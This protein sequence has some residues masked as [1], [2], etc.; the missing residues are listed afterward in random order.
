MFAAQKGR[1]RRRRSRRLMIPVAALAAGAGVASVLLMSPAHA[2][3]TTPQPPV[4]RAAAHASEPTQAE[5]RAHVAGAIKAADAPSRSAL[6]AG[7]KGTPHTVDPKII[8]GSTTAISTAPWMAQLWYYDDRGT[9]TETDDTGFF[10][11]GTV[12]S[13]TKILTAAH[14]VKGYDWSTD[15]HGTV[16]TGTDQLPTDD[17]DGTLNMHGGT[18]YGVYRQ[19]NHPSYNSVAV[20]NDVAVLTLNVPTTAKPLPVTSATDTASYTGGTTATVYGWGRTTS[21]TE[22]ISQSLKKATLPIVSSA[23]C[24]AEYGGDFIAGD[25]VCA[26]TP[27]SGSDAGTTSAC[28]GDSGGPLVVGGKIVGVVS[29]GRMDCVEKGSYSVFSRTSTYA[30]AIDARI[31]DANLTGDDKAD[32]FARTPAGAAYL[33]R[34]TGTALAARESMGDWSGFNLVRQTDLNQDDLQDFVARTTD[35]RLYYLNGQSGDAALIGSGWNVMTSLVTPGDVTGDGLP[36]LVATD[37]AG[38]AWTYPGNG[39]GW[40]GTRVKIGAGWNTYGGRIYGKGDLTGDGRPDAVAQD[41][42]GVLWLYKGTGSASA[43]WAARIKVGAGW[44]Y[45]AYAAV[46]DL[47]GDGRADLVT[48][49]TSGNL[50]LYKGTGSQSAPYAARVK[51]GYGYGIYNLFG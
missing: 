22:D 5:F 38:T 45:D 46:G 4:Y 31:D 1:G 48:R 30:G 2:G 17:A 35:G 23:A 47:T 13:P 9:A 12:V 28:N 39:K 19:W 32:L 41:A 3:N 24:T 40:F 25:M 27:A 44:T 8:G 29:W 49:D 10:C 34:S 14:C 6:A 11:G 33:Y 18:A 43:P 16:V 36:D 50:W 51:L 15:D 21:T 37:S 20:D 42:S 26:G 7:T